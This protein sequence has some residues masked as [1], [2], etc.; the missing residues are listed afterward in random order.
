MSGEKVR[1][2]K[3]RDLRRS[4]DGEGVQVGE[5]KRTEKERSSRYKRNECLFRG[6]YIQILASIQISALNQH[7]RA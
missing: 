3:M 5:G 1:T 2:E 4:E 6:L 7:T